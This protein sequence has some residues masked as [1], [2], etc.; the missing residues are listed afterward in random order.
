MKFFLRASISSDRSH[1]LCQ[2]TYSIGI[3]EIPPLLADSQKGEGHR[4]SFPKRACEGARTKS[5][6]RAADHPC[7]ARF[8]GAPIPVG[9]SRKSISKRINRAF[10][11]LSAMQSTSWPAGGGRFNRLR[12]VLRADPRARSGLRSLSVHQPQGRP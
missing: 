7:W 6:P 8:I 9:T 12:K 11:T 2:V 1:N 5:R 4:I 10:D 3:R